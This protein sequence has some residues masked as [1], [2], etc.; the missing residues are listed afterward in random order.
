MVAERCRCRALVRT[1][2]PC[3]GSGSTVAACNL[4][5]GTP[6]LG[7]LADGKPGTGRH[8]TDRA[9]VGSLGVG[10]LG[11]GSLGVGSLGMDSLGVGRAGVGRA[12]MGRAEVGRFE[13]D[14]LGVDRCG[15][16]G[17][18]A[19]GFRTDDPQEEEHGPLVGTGEVVRVRERVVGRMPRVM[20]PRTRILAGGPCR[21]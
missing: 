12:G 10:S 19:V 2:A 15:A 18:G 21:L 9:E 16:V 4:D 8:G 1:S 13:V 17:L 20:G 6:G 7:K 3:L 11:V 14:G 5:T